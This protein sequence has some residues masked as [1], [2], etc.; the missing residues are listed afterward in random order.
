MFKQFKSAFIWYHLY[1]FRKTFILVILL[2]SIVFFS[3][4]I[5]S[6]LVQYLNLRNKLEYLDYLLPIKWFIIFFNII[7]SSYLIINIFKKEKPNE[8]KN[9]KSKKEDEQD[10]KKIIKNEF[11]KREEE[12]LYKKT[13]KTK[14]DFL[15]E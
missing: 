4:F 9:K 14:A 6:D 3:S 8:E 12:F 5:Y 11:S 2:L 1:K 7:L 10:T 13:L 15:T